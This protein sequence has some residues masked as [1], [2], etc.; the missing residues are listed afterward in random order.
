M[1]FS[2]LAAIAAF[3]STVLAQGLLDQIP[4]CAQTCFG[5]SLGNC[6]PIDIGC[7][8]GS[9]VITS[10]ACCVFSTCPQADI[11]TTISFA[12]QICSLQNVQLDLTP[13]CPSNGT[14]SS[15]AAS[16]SM[17]PTASVS[18]M[19]GSASH[20]ASTAMASSATASSATASS[21]TGA[22]ASSTGAAAILQT[23]G[24]GMGFGMV[25][26]GLLAFL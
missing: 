5:N 20:A 15:S 8:C 14:S 4:K 25:M 1:R 2:I 7:I 23:A 13:D 24:T 10:V 21:A 11:N 12:T 18:G 9:N 6:G 17:S 22:S 16:G 26:A 19:S 3:S